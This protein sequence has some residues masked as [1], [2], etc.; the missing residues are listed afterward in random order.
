[1]FLKNAQTTLFF[2]RGHSLNNIV[3]FFGLFLQFGLDFIINQIKKIKVIPYK[4]NKAQQKITQLSSQQHNH[5]LERERR[6]KIKI[7]IH[8]WTV[9]EVAVPVQSAVCWSPPSLSN[10]VLSLFSSICVGKELVRF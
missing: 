10:F 3:F 9:T 5:I 2:C 6:V 1:M 4:N 8:L 7:K